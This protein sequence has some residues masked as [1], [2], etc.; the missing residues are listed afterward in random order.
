MDI[1]AACKDAVALTPL[2]GELTR[3]VENQEQIATNAL[4]DSLE[5]QSLLEEL[6]E[7]SKPKLSVGSKHLH[8]LLSTPFRYPPLKHG[9]RF[10]TRHEPSLFYGSM[11]LDTALAETAYYRQVFWSGMT[12]PP[13]SG[14]LTTELTAFGARFA[15]ERGLRL[16]ESP[17]A[18]FDARLTNPGDYSDSQQLGTELRTAGIEG[19][20]YRSARDPQ[21]GINIA[22]YSPTALNEPNPVWQEPWICETDEDSVSFYNKKFGTRRF[23][24]EQFL[25]NGN[26]PLPAL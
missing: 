26:L 8:Y 3:I 18:N 7:T 12:R 15:V 6:L 17:F 10:G 19:F 13:P 24:L 25:I 2:K 11:E 5:E 23:H 16:Y 22:I 9:S 14:K 1:W 20:E 4:V 21:R